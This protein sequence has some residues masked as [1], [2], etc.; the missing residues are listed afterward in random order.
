M[1]SAFAAALAASPWLQQYAAER[2]AA[3]LRNSPDARPGWDSH[4]R[5]YPKG[6][7]TGRERVERAAKLVSAYWELLSVATS[8]SRIEPP[9]ASDAVPRSPADR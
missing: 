1:T 6:K 5:L 3:E 7:R 4:L 9:K 8:A 2:A